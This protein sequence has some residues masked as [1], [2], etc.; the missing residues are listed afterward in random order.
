[1]E[2][3]FEKL[4]AS[5]LENKIGISDGFLTDKES[6][7]LKRHLLLLCQQNLLAKAATGN[8]DNKTFNSE[9][10]N[11]SIFWLDKKNNNIFENQFLEQ[12][13]LF[14]AYLNKTCF[15]G[16]TSYEFHYSVYENGNFYKK[17]LDQFNNNSNRQFSMIFYLNSDWKEGDGGELMIH[18]TN[19]NQ[20]ISP[21]QGKTIF[22]KS[23][24]LV[25]E[26]LVTNVQRLSITGWLK[27]N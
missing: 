27:T 14:V 13:D 17:H 6:N 15:T 11:D 10:R 5:Y 18:K 1:M 21:N 25:H 12:I 7:N 20:K 3:I 4:I 26:V 23:D 2:N 9:I 24:E 16:I 8:F 22:F 19:E